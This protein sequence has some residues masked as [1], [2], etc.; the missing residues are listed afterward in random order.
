MN[1]VL[2]CLDGSNFSKAV[3]DYGVF[4]AKN[5]DLPLV[6]LNVI[7]HSK[8]S[9]VVDFSGNIGLGAKDVLLEILVDEDAKRSQE[10]ISKGKAILKQMQEYVKSKE[11]TNFTT[12]QRHGTLY[13]TLDELGSDLK[14]AIIGLNGENS[15]DI[16]ANVE[17]LIRTLNIPILLVN[18]EFKEVNSILMAYDG[19]SYAKK[20]IDIAVKNPIFPNTKRY[21]VNINNDKNE[22]YRV[23]NEASLIFKN[24]NI[25][26]ETSSLSGDKLEAIL[27]YQQS[28]NA[29][30]IAMGAY[31]HNRFRSAIFGSFTTNM[32]LKSKVPLL[33]FR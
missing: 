9:N 32:I 31:S 8:I 27:N 22:S 25:D 7:E 10:Q 30:I 28:I 6:L 5:L 26:V 4:I 17:E 1:K 23:L 3:C 2:V 19:S 18:S 21:I 33:L 20:S 14:I 11:F 29:D 24:A 12:L 13:E 15:K 16:G